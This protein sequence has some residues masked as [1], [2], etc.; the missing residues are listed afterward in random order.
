MDR[1]N[2]EI[3]EELAGPLRADFGSDNLS[4]F[5]D[6]GENYTW[7]SRVFDAAV[8]CLWWGTGSAG[9][10]A[11]S[12]GSDFGAAVRLTCPNLSGKLNSKISG[13]S[14]GVEVGLGGMG[15]GC[16]GDSGAAL[17]QE[18]GGKARIASNEGWSILVGQV[19]KWAGKR[20]AGEVGGSTSLPEGGY[21]ERTPRA[22]FPHGSTSAMTTQ[23]E[24]GGAGGVEI[25][26]SYV[27]EYPFTSP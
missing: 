21:G 13:V 3:P 27:P 19:F 4:I 14:D 7:P 6:L 11:R 10:G 12:G 18:D 23:G 17:F 8:E 24:S 20:S 25:H 5:P 26:S 22:V 9:A 1:T 16:R 15:R 2:L